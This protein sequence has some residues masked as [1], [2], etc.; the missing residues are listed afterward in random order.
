MGNHGS[1]MV[2][3]LALELSHNLLITAYILHHPFLGGSCEAWLVVLWKTDKLKCVPLCTLSQACDHSTAFRTSCLVFIVH[4]CHPWWF[5]SEYHCSV[6]WD[7]VIILLKTWP[8]L[9]GQWAFCFLFQNLSL[10][11]H[12]I[13]LKTNL[14]IT[15][16][17]F[18][19]WAHSHSSWAFSSTP[20]GSVPFCVFSS[21]IHYHIYLSSPLLSLSFCI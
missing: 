7:E 8:S 9:P 11:S 10:D 4:L 17:W 1:P 13:W 20:R 15:H 6:E 14:L 16:Q 18:V 19:S 2:V 5:Y 12:M 3:P 21:T